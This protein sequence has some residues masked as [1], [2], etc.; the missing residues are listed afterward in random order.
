MIYDDNYR[1]LLEADL[2]QERRGDPRIILCLQG[3]C[4]DAYLDLFR[5]NVRHI[6]YPRSP[7]A[8]DALV[9]AASAAFKHVPSEQISINVLDQETHLLTN[10]Q[11]YGSL[12][13]RLEA[14]LVVNDYDF[15]AA[16]AN[17]VLQEAVT[18]SLFHSFREKGSHD[19]KYSPDNFLGLY[20]SDTVE[21]TFTATSQYLSIKVKDNS[22]SL[23]PL[24]VA[25][26]LD[27]H[28]S[29]RGVLDTRGRGFY[30]M[31]HLTHRMVITVKRGEETSL[32]L[33][34]LRK[35]P[36]AF[37]RHLELVEL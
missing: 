7:F 2:Q 33:F 31:R 4:R 27:R 3:E 17:L 21:V 37:R 14:F 24:S 30:L 28:R 1:Q 16:N 23:G 22:G 20:D 19:R 25:N 15:L 36:E 29:E 18:N 8:S 12:P 26:S 9:L 10:V 6:I 5:L 11:D 35:E 13:N 34:F 32:E